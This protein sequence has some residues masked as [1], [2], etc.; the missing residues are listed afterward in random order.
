MDEEIESQLISA[1]VD[2]V[3]FKKH[4][5]RQVAVIAGQGEETENMAVK[6]STG[7]KQLRP[8]L[9]E[10]IDT[11][12]YVHIDEEVTRAD[13]GD[14]FTKLLQSEQVEKYMV[15]GA[16]PENIADALAENF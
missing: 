11:M 8:H 1:F 10:C 2:L 14:F 9:K 5:G 3:L 13:I 15:I 16:I 4:T 6:L 7:V 12:F